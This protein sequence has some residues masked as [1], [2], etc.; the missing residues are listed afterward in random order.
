[1]KDELLGSIVDFIEMSGGFASVK[2]LA[3]EMSVS[4]MTIRRYLLILEK[5]GSIARVSAGAV[6]Q[7]NLREGDDDLIVALRHFEKEKRA[8]AAYAATL[9]ENRQ[10]IFLDTGSTCYHVATNLPMDCR[11]T[12]ITYSLDIVSA[13]RHRRDIRVICP[14]G[15]LDSTLNVF[16]GPHAEQTLS[17]FTA[18]LALLGAGGIDP[19]LGTQE[20]TLVQIPLKRIMSRN[21]NNSY[22]LLDSSKLGH[23]S[24]FSGTP[25]S[26]IRNIIT[27]TAA[28]SVQLSYLK[29]AGIAVT[30]V[31]VD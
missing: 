31:P 18:D 7:H 28:D 15:E 13:L 19:G 24:Y 16:A 4:E 29:A 20:N 27:T 30:S 17:S 3:D 25:V 11:L 26:E 6:R 9:V 5:R 10:L 12:V 8:I 21:S 14:G 1:M 2:T 23:R 22:L